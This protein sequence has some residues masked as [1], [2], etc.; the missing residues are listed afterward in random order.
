V[1]DFVAAGDFVQP[2]DERGTDVRRVPHE[3]LVVEDVAA[4]TVVAA[5][6]EVRAR[7]LQTG[8]RA[9]IAVPLTS[10]ARVIGAF[11]VGSAS[12][13]A[14]TSDHMDTA[15]RVADL[16]GPFIENIAAFRREQRRRTR[17]E[18]LAGL[19]EVLGTSLNARDVFDRLAGAVR[20]ILDFDTMGATLFGGGDH[21][22]EY[23]GRV[24]GR[25]GP[26]RL[27]RVSAHDFSFSQT[28]RSGQAVVVRDAATSASYAT[29]SSAPSLSATGS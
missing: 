17:L 24:T 20:S 6:P 8:I 22:V 29:P 3:T 13:A 26:E 21:D 16:I 18:G 12:P 4:G 5:G 25:A 27:S 19:M 23:L 1:D 10:G 2:A 28:L 14:F 7:L 11:L 15:R 9:L